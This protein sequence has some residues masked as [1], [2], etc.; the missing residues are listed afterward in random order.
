MFD[1]CDLGNGPVILRD[2]KRF[3][4]I[5]DITAPPTQVELIVNVPRFIDFDQDITF[6]ATV[7]GISNYLITFEVSSHSTHCY[8]TEN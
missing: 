5:D 4:N 8:Y 2:C 3:R 6:S 1:F 7:S